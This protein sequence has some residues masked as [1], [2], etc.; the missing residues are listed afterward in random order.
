MGT[1]VW[2]TIDFLWASYGHLCADHY[3]LLWTSYGVALWS[4]RLCYSSSLSEGATGGAAEDE[5]AGAAALLHAT[6]LQ[7]IQD[8]S[9]KA[10][11]GASYS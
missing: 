4:R 1:Y 3:G 7:Q 8:A 11:V 2:T 5:H 9:L 10:A 6:A